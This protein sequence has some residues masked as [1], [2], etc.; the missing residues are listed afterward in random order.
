MSLRHIHIR[1]RKS[2]GLEPYPA[3]S[4]WLRALDRVVL[5]AGV[6]GPIATIP[7]IINIYST[8]SAG[9]VSALTFGV[10]A[11]FNIF[12]ILYGLAHKE[13]PIVLTF[14]LWLVVNTI[15]ALGALTYGG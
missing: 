3:K 12:W 5:L 4:F 8:H 2:R 6:V 11:F 10:Y 1:K 7:Q 15:V 9:N 13:F 14:C